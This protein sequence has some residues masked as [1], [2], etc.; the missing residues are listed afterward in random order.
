MREF[1]GIDKAL[2]RIKGELANNAEN[3]TDI[4]EHITREQKSLQKLK[5]VQISEF[6]KREPKGSLQT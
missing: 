5:L 3:L 6:M 1:E 2:T 4:D